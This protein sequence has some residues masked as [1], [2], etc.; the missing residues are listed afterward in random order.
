MDQ[1]AGMAKSEQTVRVGG[2]NLTLSNVEKVLYPGNRFTKGQMIDYYVRV[3][4]HILPHLKDRPITLKRY[5]EGVRGEFFYE[6]NAPAF[7]PPWVKRFAVSRHRHAGVIHYIL[8]NDLPTLVWVANTAS[9]ELHPFLHRVPRIRV[10]TEIVFDLDPGEGADIVSCARVAILVRELL[11]E[12]KLK[13]FVK[14]SGSKGLQLYVPLNGKL[15]YDA[16]KQFAKTIAE[17]M[18][19]RHADLVVAKMAKELRKGKVFIDWSQNSETKTTVCVY[20]LRAKADVPYV[21]LPVTWDELAAAERAN[22]ARSLFFEPHEALKRLTK[23]GDLFADVEKLKQNLPRDILEAGAVD[24]P[25]KSL[26]KY[27]AK[28]DFSKTGEPPPA[29]PGRS[30]QGSTRRFVVQKHAASHV[31]YDFRLEM[32]GVLKS[33]AVPKGLPLVPNVNRL[34]MP[35]EDHPLDYLSF[36]GIIP[37]GQY[38]GGT[39]MVWDIGTYNLIEGNV[40]RGSLKFFLAGEKLNGEW[41]LTRGPE[42][43]GRPKWYMIKADH[44][45]LRLPKAK[46]DKSALSG[47]TMEQIAAKPGR[48]WQSNREAHAGPRHSTARNAAQ[49][50]RREIPDVDSLPK[51]KIRFVEP[52]L[53]KLVSEVPESPDW[54]YEIKLDGYRALVVR[55]DGNVDVFSRC[56]NRLNEKYPEIAKALEA[57]PPDTVLDGEIVALDAKGRPDFNTLQNWKRGKNLFF[58]AFDILA[59]NGRDVSRLPLRDRRR[60]LDEAL[61]RRSDPI[62]LSPVLD[63]PAKQIVRAA[64]ENGLEGVVGKRRDSKYEP[65]ERSGAWVKYKT[66]KSQELVIGGYS[67][68]KHGFDSLLVGYYDDGKL[69]FNAKVRNGFTPALRQQVSK[70][71]RGL[72]TSKCPFANLPE[73]KNARRGKALTKEAMKECKWLK[74]KLVAQ[75]E[76]T[77][78]TESNHL[79][80]ATFAGIREDKVPREVIKES[81]SATRRRNANHNMEMRSFLQ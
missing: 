66:Q 52:M 10:A 28:R 17:L 36:E 30:R 26:E 35:T 33:W 71:F 73:P 16:T 3:A 24:P 69:I 8:I 51:A 37:K 31:H 65:G 15:E 54:Q 80:E 1:G 34:A 76:F 27:R 4:P 50:A 47:R 67:P 29:T 22:D 46:A 5:P 38:G 81:A 41:V 63:F 12:M 74:P 78:W 48:E 62:R 61:S 79:R 49:E 64:R 6:K 32:E 55:R 2:R 42:E 9:I 23:T 56:E 14:V 45:T 70:R 18:E 25:P 39:V 72:E 11:D 60:I 75:V 19:Q 44:K 58:Y 77:D 53:A 68:G 21:S 57:L 40:H 59:Y 43:G 7:T 13:S 20:S